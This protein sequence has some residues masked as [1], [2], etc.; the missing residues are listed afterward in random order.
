MGL[1]WSART[2]KIWVHV[3]DVVVNYLVRVRHGGGDDVGE[4]L[5][6]VATLSDS[7]CVAVVNV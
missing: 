6:P 4:L 1:R 5:D 2:H 7:E 3:L